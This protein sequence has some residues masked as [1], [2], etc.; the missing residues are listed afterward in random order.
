TGVP[1]GLVFFGGWRAHRA[2]STSAIFQQA[3]LIDPRVKQV[4]PL[5]AQPCLSVTL[6]AERLFRKAAGG[7]RGSVCLLELPRP[8]HASPLCQAAGSH[9]SRQSQ[10]LVDLTGIRH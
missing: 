1:P 10:A 7:S 9:Q 2:V 8:G 3:A 5:L 4:P 6:A